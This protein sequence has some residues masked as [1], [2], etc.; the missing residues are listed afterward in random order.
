MEFIEE[1]NPQK[2]LFKR[3]PE[4]Q[5]RGNYNSVI[6]NENNN[7]K[8]LVQLINIKKSET[9]IIKLPRYYV[10]ESIIWLPI[11][12]IFELDLKRIK[13]QIDLLIDLKS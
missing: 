11:G 4:L 12:S 10:I 3:R 13:V 7:L 2:Q 5:S 9:S 1:T 6:K 8:R